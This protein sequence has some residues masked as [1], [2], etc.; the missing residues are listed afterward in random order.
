MKL[1]V[2]PTLLAL[3]PQVALADDPRVGLYA[4]DGDT[5]RLVMDRADAATPG[6]ALTILLPEIGGTLVQVARQ[7]V[8]P[9]VDPVEADA[10]IYESP[11]AWA[12]DPVPG[13][14]Y[15][16]I[17]VFA[18]VDGTMPD[19]DGNGIPETA[20]ACT[21]SESVQ[22]ALTEGTGNAMRLVWW[23]PVYLGYDTEPTCPEELFAA[24]ERAQ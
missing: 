14:D 18:P 9:A 5:A 7:S 8:G 17:A 24:I 4:R 23:L 10:M 22:L 1:L 2:I 19:T 11:A 12:L 15:F 20:I 21:S 3:L 16:G 13:E 6:E